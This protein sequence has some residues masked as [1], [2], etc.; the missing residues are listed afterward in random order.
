MPEVSQY[1]KDLIPI[2]KEHILEISGQSEVSQGKVPQGARAGVTIAYLQEEDDTKLGPTVQEYEECMERV[3]WLDLQVIAQE[4]D[5]PRTVRI[6][7]KHSEP[8]VRDFIGTMLL[9]IAGVRVQAGSALP[10]SKAAKQQFI[11]D[12]FDRQIET[13]PR[14][15]REM[16]ELSEGEPD[17]LEKI[18]AS[19]ERE[20]RKMLNGQEVVVLEWHNHD[21]HRQ[22]LH[23]F[24]MS[25]EWDE[26]P[27][28]VQQIMIKHD[29]DHAAE[30][31]KAATQQMVMQGMAG[32]G[33]QPAPGPGSN[34]AQPPQN[35]APAGANGNNATPP[36]Q[37]QAAEGGPATSGTAQQHP[38]E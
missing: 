25:P 20:N 3:A 2:L 27:P 12:L 14:K 30:Q 21:V 34:G 19:A 33:Q 17:E 18:I 35:T 16:L 15:V 36:P 8:E 29:E 5:I 23:D 11:L 4:Y 6:Y 13:D 28:Q 10:R 31:R 7:K 32:G 24:M 9:G 22:I 37:F 26:T 1:I 38:P